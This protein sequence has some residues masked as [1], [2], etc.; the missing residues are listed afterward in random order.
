MDS[1]LVLMVA[2][3][4]TKWKQTFACDCEKKAVNGITLKETILEAVEGLEAIDPDVAV[5]FCVSPGPYFNLLIEF[6]GVRRKKPYLV[7]RHKKIYAMSDPPHVLRS[8]Q[9]WLDDEYVSKSSTGRAKWSM[10]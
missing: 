4:Q 9:N 6:L 3:L 8:T 10:I 5:F 2:G 7:H 1:A